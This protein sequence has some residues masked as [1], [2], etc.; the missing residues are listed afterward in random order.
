MTRPVHGLGQIRF[1][2]NLHPTRPNRVDKISTPSL[3]KRMMGSGGLEL[4]Q[5]TGRSVGVEDLENDENL[6]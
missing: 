3:T 2:L 6:V 1:V 4:Q 5:P